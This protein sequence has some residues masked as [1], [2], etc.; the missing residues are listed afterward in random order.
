MIDLSIMD[1]VFGDNVVL[2][3]NY[4]NFDKDFATLFSLVPDTVSGSIVF[5]SGV[6]GFSF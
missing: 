4:S 5:C 3:V 6:L 1:C 2:E